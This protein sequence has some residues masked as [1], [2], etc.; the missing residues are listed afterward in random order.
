MYLRCE[1]DANNAVIVGYGDG[2]YF[3]Q[4][5]LA[6]A[7]TTIDT[8]TWNGNTSAFRLNFDT[9][10]NRVWFDTYQDGAGGGWTNRTWEAIPIA[11]T[12]LRIV[13]G[14]GTYQAVVSPGQGRWESVNQP[15]VK[16]LAGFSAGVAASTAAPTLRRSLTG[17]SVGLAAAAGASSA[18]RSLVANA[19]GVALAV[20]GFAISGLAR[21]VAIADAT[22][23]RGRRVTPLPLLALTDDFNDGSMAAIWTTKSTG[24][25]GGTIVESGGGL[26]VTVPAN[27]GV[28][29]VMRGYA[30]AATYDLTGKAVLVELVQRGSLE[31]SSQALLRV[32]VASDPANSYVEVGQSGA[33]ILYKFR[34]NQGAP[35]WPAG[36]RFLRIEFDNGPTGT[37]AV[38]WDWSA[39]GTTWTAITTSRY[40]VSRD[41]LGSVTA[42]RVLVIGKSYFGNVTAPLPAIFD[43][44]DI[45]VRP[46]IGTATG[47]ST[48]T[49]ATSSRRSLVGLSAGVAAAS[50]SALLRGRSL[51]AAST[52]VATAAATLTRRRSL[53]VASAGS[54]TASAA[55]TARR[56]LS[57]SSAG[58]ATA[59]T[60]QISK[61]GIVTNASNGRATTSATLSARRSIT[62]SSAGLATTTAAPTRRRV[63]LAV[64]TATSTATASVSDRRALLAASVGKATATALAS[65]RRLLGTVSSAGRATALGIIG[66]KGSLFA[67]SRGTTSVSVT[68]TARRSLTVAS[69]GS[70]TASAQVWRGVSLGFVSS[71][72]NATATGQI[73]RTL[74][75]LV[76][77]ATGTSSATALIGRKRS[78]VVSSA[79]T[80]LEVVFIGR[81]R[82][83]APVIAAG[84][85]VTTAVPTRRRSMTVMSVGHAATSGTVSVRIALSLVYWDWGGMQFWSAATEDATP[86]PG[87][88]EITWATDVDQFEPG[89]VVKA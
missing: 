44:F 7:T 45:P 11:T 1:V 83:L 79:G 50:I 32:E 75:S 81:K 54:A 58:A 51:T 78:L 46:L 38:Y 70:G 20:G 89:E 2:A 8:E 64:A 22:I 41:G 15:I 53:A 42:C 17:A 43:N 47:V 14:T 6:G 10:Q 72:G 73:G 29:E 35:A 33:S 24:G 5:Q 71:V 25:T 76:A 30:T 3:A 19:A 56:S 74:P 69:T 48:T 4:H 87:M 86:R 36:A 28:I 34:S 18:R 27:A 84:R 12:A 68:V 88:Q 37:G 49:A 60:V 52:A 61:P 16:N 9:A 85:A 21:G 63:L 13:L 59:P 77:H 82:S 40:N 66:L 57:G 31:T 67:L 62:A 55:P 26:N 39:N 65:A 23:I 80:T